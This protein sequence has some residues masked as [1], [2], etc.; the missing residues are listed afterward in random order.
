MS[1]P[2]VRDDRAEG[3]IVSRPPSFDLMGSFWLDEHGN[4]YRVDGVHDAADPRMSL[5]YVEPPQRKQLPMSVLRG[6]HLRANPSATDPSPSAER[7]GEAPPN[8]EGGPS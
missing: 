2:P 1:R 6:T 7:G 3:A 5:A 4:T 8:P